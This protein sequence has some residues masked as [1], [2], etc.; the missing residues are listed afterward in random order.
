MEEEVNVDQQEG[1]QDQVTSNRTNADD[2]EAEKIDLTHT[3]SEPDD[4][5][6]ISDTEDAVK[7]IVTPTKPAA[8]PKLT[9]QTLL[10]GYTG[11]PHLTS[12]QHL[13]KQQQKPKD[14]VYQYFPL[15]N[16]DHRRD[17]DRQTARTQQVGSNHRRQIEF[18]A[19]PWITTDERRSKRFP[20]SQCDICSMSPGDHRYCQWPCKNRFDDY[21]A[22]NGLDSFDPVAVFYP[23]SNEPGEHHKGDPRNRYARY[24]HKKQGIFHKKINDVHTGCPLVAGKVKM[25]LDLGYMVAE[26]NG[27]FGFRSV[28]EREWFQHCE[29][30]HYDILLPKTWYDA[31]PIVKAYNQRLSSNNFKN[32][33]NTT[34]IE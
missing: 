14:R 31:V 1:D 20:R 33:Q 3:D 6:I 22:R 19:Q 16:N 8:G 18:G 21:A 29:S 27:N 11:M 25:I 12:Y 2:D 17:N 9:F 5:E 32:F 7:L 34:R 26:D 23:F 15:L 4:V 28:L 30:I 13:P 24:N 10:T